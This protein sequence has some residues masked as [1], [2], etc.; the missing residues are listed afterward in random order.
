MFCREK[1][2]R[3]YQGVDRTAPPATVDRTAQCMHARV[4]G[5]WSLR[6]L[7]L[8]NI[9]RVS[10]RD[11]VEENPLLQKRGYVTHNLS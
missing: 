3:Y 8:I 2:R 6:K 7:V 1:D 10:Y 4:D 5:H 11:I 9:L